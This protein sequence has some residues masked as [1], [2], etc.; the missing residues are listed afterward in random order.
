MKLS[1][2]VS[3]ISLLFFRIATSSAFPSIEDIRFGIDLT[4]HERY[5]NAID[6]FTRIKND[7]PEHPAGSFFLAAVWQSRMLDFE[8]FR[9]EQVYHQHLEE[10]IRIAEGRLRQNP[11]DIDS[12]FFLGAA[13]SYKSYDAARRKK[14]LIAIQTALRS[15]KHLSKVTAADSLFCDAYL[16]IGSYKYWRS[17]LTENFSWLPFFPDQKSEGIEMLEKAGECGIYTKWVSLSNLAWIFIEEKAYER[18][19]EISKSALV[20]F[21]HS[22][23][24]LW[25]LGD[26]QFKNGEFSKAL[27]TYNTLLTSVVNADVNNHYNEITLH[28]KIAQCHLELGND[29]AAKQECLSALGIIP[30]KEVEKRCRHKKDEAIGV[31]NELSRRN[32][33]GGRR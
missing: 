20:H 13:L 27:V 22:R 25:P 8:T 14:Y 29:E 11:N 32:G 9:W 10:T 4:I 33:A 12:R 31:L 16:G 3:L 19:I 23:F 24:F 2:T 30:D 18:A 15:I 21:P 1:T 6:H 17:R 7:F 28:V 26:A 5:D